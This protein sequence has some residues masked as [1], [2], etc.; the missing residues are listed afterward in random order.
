MSKAL[1]VLCLLLAACGT[2]TKSPSNGSML[3][4]TSYIEVWPEQ[5]APANV[6]Y[7]FS[8]STAQELGM[9][10][11][12][13]SRFLQLLTGPGKSQAKFSKPF[14]VAFDEA[15]NICMVDSGSASVWFFDLQ[16]NSFKVWQEVGPYRIT[17]PTSIAR[18]GGIF[19]LADSAIGSVLAFRSGKEL[20]K[21]FKEGL[22]R[23]S[24]VA[25]FSDKV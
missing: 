8:F 20:L 18:S 16:E 6:G 25:V 17:S 15:G 12:G 5:P 10:D 4:S 3:S 21:E 24:G 23:P 13:W 11:S 7:L 22:G 19:Y 14:S 1:G 9:R 2:T